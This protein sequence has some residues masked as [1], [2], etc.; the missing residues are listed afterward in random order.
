MD[1]YTIATS[2]IIIPMV[3]SA[4]FLRAFLYILTANAERQNPIIAIGNAKI[5]A[6]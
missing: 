2:P 5:E 4:D 1:E 3:A 6:Q